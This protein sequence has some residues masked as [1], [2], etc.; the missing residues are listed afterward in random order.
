MNSH[1]PRLRAFCH[2]HSLCEARFRAAQEARKHL[3]RQ[4]KM[5]EY[6]ERR[7]LAQC[8]FFAIFCGV[9]TWKIMDIFHGGNYI[10]N[11]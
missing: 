6:Q 10:V 5:E 1:I 2:S 3:E 8:F 4:V 7:A 11:I 9:Y